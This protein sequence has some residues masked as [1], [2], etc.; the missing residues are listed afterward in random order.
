[1]DE[2]EIS[3]SFFFESQKKWNK[4]QYCVHCTTINTEQLRMHIDIYSVV[5]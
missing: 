5:L 4:A 1:M 3:N 2:A